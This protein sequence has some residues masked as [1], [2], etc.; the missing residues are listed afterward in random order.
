MGMLCYHRN[1]YVTP[2]QVLFL[3]RVDYEKRN[4][5]IIQ[6]KNTLNCLKPDHSGSKNTQKLS[7]KWRETG[8]KSRKLSFVSQKVTRA[9]FLRFQCW[10]EWDR[11]GETDRKKQGDG[12]WPTESHPAPL[13][14]QNR[15]IGKERREGGSKERRKGVK[16]TKDLKNKEKGRKR[17]QWRDEG[18]KVS[19]S[20]IPETQSLLITS[21]QLIFHQCFLWAAHFLTSF[22]PHWLP[23]CKQI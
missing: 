2:C 5:Q 17:I 11:K 23:N 9:R 4:T 12:V 13:R 19:Y 16:G 1:K 7:H 8:I 10:R 20:H 21:E 14:V 6:Q 3:T 22:H 18:L 15:Q